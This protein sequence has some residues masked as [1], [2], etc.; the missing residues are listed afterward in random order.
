MSAIVNQTQ[1][2][3]RAAQG[4]IVTHAVQKAAP[5]Q[6]NLTGSYPRGG[7]GAESPQDELMRM[8]MEAISA[9]GGSGKTAFGQVVATDKDFRY[10]QKKRETEAL[11]NFDAWVGSNF[12]TNDVTTRKWLQETFPEYYETRER[13]MVDRAKLALRINLLKLRGPKTQE[14]LIIQWGL[15]TGRIKLDENWD[16]IGFN[17]NAGQTPVGQQARFKKGLFAPKRYLTQRERSDNATDLTNPFM[18]GSFT[19]QGQFQPDTGAFAG[20][21]VSTRNRYPHFLEQVIKPQV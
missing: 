4:G 18:P 13:M 21:Q 7:L 8:K 6:P 20:E 19:T 12:H 10:L 15:Q 11:A 9:G 17:V 14:D 3:T 5:G 1:N 2:I 16:R